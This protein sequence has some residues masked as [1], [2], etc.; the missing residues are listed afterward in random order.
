[1]YVSRITAVKIDSVFTR[2]GKCCGCVG[3]KVFYVI[4]ANAGRFPSFLHSMLNKK[5]FVFKFYVRFVT[6]F[7][8]FM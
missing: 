2:K 8:N 4:C 6:A 7:Y 1:V 5:M 3:K